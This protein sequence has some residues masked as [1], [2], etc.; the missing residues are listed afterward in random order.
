[1]SNFARATKWAGMSADDIPNAVA[2]HVAFGDWQVSELSAFIV[3]HDG[4]PGPPPDD[5]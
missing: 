5:R 1:M 4:H 2:S 3:L